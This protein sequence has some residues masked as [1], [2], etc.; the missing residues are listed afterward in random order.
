MADLDGPGASGLLVTDSAVDTYFIVVDEYIVE[1]DTVY[2]GGAYW[3]TEFEDDKCSGFM[4]SPVGTIVQ[5]SSCSFFKTA[6]QDDTMPTPP[7]AVAIFNAEADVPDGFNA[8]DLEIVA[9]PYLLDLNLQVPDTIC[10][11]QVLNTTVELGIKTFPDELLG[12]QLN[13]PEFVLAID[14]PF[15]GDTTA[16]RIDEG[17][18]HTV[19]P[20]LTIPN[21]LTPG[22]TGQIEARLV[23]DK[24]VT[25]SSD[26]DKIVVSEDVSIGVP[27]IEASSDYPIA[28]LPGEVGQGSIIVD[29]VGTCASTIQLRGLL[30]GIQE[31]T[32]APGQE[33]SIDD[34]FDM[35]PEPLDIDIE[36]VRTGSGEVEA[37][38]NEEI[39]PR[40]V[41]IVDT[42]EGVVQVY[43]GVNE[44]LD[45]G[46]IIQGTNLEVNSQSSEGIG[47][48]ANTDIVSFV[49]EVPDEVKLKEII[50][51]GS[52]QYI[53]VQVEDDILWVLDGE[54]LG[55]AD[56]FQYSAYPIGQV[57]SRMP[58]VADDPEI[59]LTESPLRNKVKNITR[60]INF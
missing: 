47:S 57:S 52:T 7:S 41:F 34:Q 24:G 45:V 21:D 9:P 23:V 42:S 16:V 43:G 50:S 1:G 60:S 3:G 59:T 10:A 56:S 19:E 54:V 39:T 29:N 27:E 51:F 35:P 25:S 14:N 40:E 2:K 6:I 4:M 17:G 31:F 8:D 48:I 46:G 13:K 22:D 30:S 26:E 55:K 38:F 11:G 37:S 18:Q 53:N 20:Q 28:I 5:D 58:T 15:T 44:P 33:V 36:V 12:V 49:D 32:I